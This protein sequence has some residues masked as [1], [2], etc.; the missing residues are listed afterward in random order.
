MT[1]KSTYYLRLEPHEAH[2]ASFCVAIVWGLIAGLVSSYAPFIRDYGLYI[3]P[4]LG[5]LFPWAV[6]KFT[7]ASA[8]Y[9]YGFKSWSHRAYDLCGVIV[10][11]VV[12]LVH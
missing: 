1:L 4:I 12:Y 2:H 10:S 3:S 8:H 5:Y 7:F 11:V 9:W 6:C